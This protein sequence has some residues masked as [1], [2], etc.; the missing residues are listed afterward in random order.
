VSGEPLPSLFRPGPFLEFSLR[1]LGDKPLAAPLTLT[2]PSLGSS[3][4]DPLNGPLFPVYRLR[5]TVLPGSG[6]GMLRW[7]GPEGSDVGSL[8][9]AAGLHL[10]STPVLPSDYTTFLLQ[11]MAQTVTGGSL[12]F[13]I[14]LPPEK[15][16]TRPRIPPFRQCLDAD[17]RKTIIDLLNEAAP[18]LPQPVPP[19]QKPAEPPPPVA[20]DSEINYQLQIFTGVQEVVHRKIL[21]SDPST[22]TSRETQ[23]LAGVNFTIQFHRDDASGKE[24]QFQLQFAQDLYF[25]DPSLTGTA[26][27][28]LPKSGQA[29]VAYNYVK[30]VNETLSLVFSAQGSVGYSSQTDDTHTQGTIQAGGAGSIGANYKVN[31]W[32]TMGATAQVGATFG[33]GV[34]RN[35]LKFSPGN[36]TTVDFTAMYTV[37]VDL[38]KVKD[39]LKNLIRR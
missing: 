9:P 4:R 12:S 2:L 19:G 8:V 13:W 32:L 10:W 39:A 33:P 7:S 20:A 22:A 16:G 1:A 18:P 3:L 11:S 5:S 24:I 6:E 25:R 27:L 35:G 17:L 29:S 37:S 14:N 30:V 21:P 34:N 15:G 28:Q 36:D 23:A 38:D 31:S 26:A